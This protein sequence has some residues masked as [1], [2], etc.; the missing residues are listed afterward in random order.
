M[1][2]SRLYVE[3]VGCNLMFAEESGV[4]FPDLTKVGLRSSGAVSLDPSRLCARPAGFVILLRR[5]GGRTGFALISSLLS[6]ADSYCASSSESEATSAEGSRGEAIDVGFGGTCG[7][8]DIMLARLC[9][10][11]NLAGFGAGFGG[12]FDLAEGGLACPALAALGIGDASADT[13]S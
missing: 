6:G 8:D 11:E 13:L 10:P 2:D 4:T 12:G 3:L 9:S 7:G 5:G 1:A